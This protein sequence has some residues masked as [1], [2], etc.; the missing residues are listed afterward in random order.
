[1]KNYKEKKSTIHG[2]NTEIYDTPYHPITIVNLK[3]TAALKY[4]HKWNV[5]GL[6]WPSK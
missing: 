1:M 2:K 4:G 6:N 3:R 5:S